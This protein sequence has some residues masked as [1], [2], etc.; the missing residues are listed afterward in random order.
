MDIDFGIYFNGLRGFDR[1]GTS[2]GRHI[3]TALDEIRKGEN[4][5]LYI[6]I[7]VSI[8]VAILSAFQIAQLELVIGVLL[9]I[10]A[11]IASSLLVNRRATEEVKNTNQQLIASF[12]E[13]KH[14]T[15]KRPKFGDIL[16]EGFPDLKEEIDGAKSVSILGAVLSTSVSRYNANF[17]QLI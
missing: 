9:T 3:K 2:M 12:N 13:I 17:I 7:F 16:R 6:T 8:I 5:D 1:T 11:I 10:I 14:A 15:E 4:L